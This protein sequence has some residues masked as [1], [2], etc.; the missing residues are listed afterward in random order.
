MC[1]E[2]KR[3][4]KLL[5]CEG[6]GRIGNMLTACQH[7]ALF[8]FCIL[9]SFHWDTFQKGKTK[10]VFASLFIEDS[11]HLSEAYQVT[12]RNVRGLT[13]CKSLFCNKCRI[14]F[15][16]LEKTSINSHK[17]VNLMFLYYW[18]LRKACHTFTVSG[19]FSMLQVNSL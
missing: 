15:S 7:S 18:L 13:Q 9:S 6:D 11:F 8:L 1:N 16:H 2:R 19:F 3:C 17:R 4:V 14:C 5:Q 12:S 10:N